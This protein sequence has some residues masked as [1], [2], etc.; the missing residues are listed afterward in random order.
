MATAVVDTA[1]TEGDDPLGL[2]QFLEPIVLKVDE[3]VWAVQKSQDAL[4]DQIYLLQQGSFR[5][6]YFILKPI[7]I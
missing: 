6:R 5:Y 3:S 4:S 7:T 2:I 1:A